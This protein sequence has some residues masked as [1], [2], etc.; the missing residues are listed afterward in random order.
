MFVIDERDEIIGGLIDDWDELLVSI[1][2]FAVWGEGD[3]NQE[4]FKDVLFRTWKLFNKRIDFDA[5]YNNYSL[6]IGMAYILGRMMEY[7]D[8][9]QVTGRADGGN[10]EFSAGIV[11][12]LADSIMNREYF[13]REKPIIEQ[14]ASIDGMFALLSYNCETGVLT[15][16][17]GLEEDAPQSFAYDKDSN[18]KEIKRK[19]FDKTLE[20]TDLSGWWN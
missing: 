2:D 17:N 16:T 3:F 7:S 19:P 10:I 20:I 6:P 12:G 13:P 14:H 15:V 4:L 9:I 11:K 5:E 1:E 8:Q 18:L